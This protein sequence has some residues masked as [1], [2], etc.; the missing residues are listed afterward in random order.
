[1]TDFMK[2]QA[3]YD[4]PTV[5][6]GT[7]GVPTRM[8]GTKRCDGCWEVETRLRDYLNTGERAKAFVR[9]ALRKVRPLPRKHS[10]DGR[11][12]CPICSPCRC[13]KAP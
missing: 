12:R 13:S 2:P 3:S 5:P 1:M 10:R 8:T 9:A 6:C 11:V 7:C 4:P